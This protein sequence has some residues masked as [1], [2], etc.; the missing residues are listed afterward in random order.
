ML[1]F[2]SYLIAIVQRLLAAALMSMLTLR[3]SSEWSLEV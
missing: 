1:L 2:L 3:S